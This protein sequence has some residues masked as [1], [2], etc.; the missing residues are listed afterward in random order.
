MY[1]LVEIILPKENKEDLK[2]IFNTKGIIDYW[3]EES[4][5]NKIAYK[6]LIQTPFS[7]TLL[8]KLSKFK[9]IRVIVSDIITTLPQEETTIKKRKIKLSREE[10][11]SQIEQSISINYIYITMIILSSLIAGFGFATNNTA[12][13][14]G[15]MVIAPLLG[16]NIATSLGITLG[17][18]DLAKK[19]GLT[20][21][22][23][24][25]LAYFISIFLGLIVNISP[26]IPQINSRIHIHY[27]DV[28]IAISSGIAGV[29]AFTSGYAISLVGVMVA[30][31]L[32]PPLVSSGMLLGSGYFF[33][34][35]LALLLF[36]INIVSLILSGVI[37][38]RFQGIKPKT[39]WQ[40]QKAK[41]YRKNA[42]F[43]SGFLLL[44]F[45]LIIYIN[46]KIKGG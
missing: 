26:Q 11:Y 21:L 23:G 16:P 32:L 27:S 12:V 3:Q 13:I 31:S 7:Q 42:I 22:I 33:Y 4:Y 35:F 43:M 9:D 44:F 28:I 24:S 17:D 5:K 38:F 34:S 18:M 1:R 2:T 15:A 46:H 39:W 6:I 14:I 36:F 10:L 25:A 19:A 8:D 30:I 45:I 41:I 40:E 29:L 37:T 20:L